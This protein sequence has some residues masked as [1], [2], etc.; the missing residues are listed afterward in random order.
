MTIKKPREKNIFKHVISSKTFTDGYEG[1]VCASSVLSRQRL[2]DTWVTYFLLCIHST[3]SPARVFE[4]LHHAVQRGG[5]L[6][7]G[8][9]QIFTAILT[10]LFHLGF[11]NFL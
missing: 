6:T 7:L 10:H 9:I 2:T 8:G 4:G 5:L 3:T 1:F 11:F